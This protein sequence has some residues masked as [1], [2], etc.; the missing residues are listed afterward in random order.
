MYRDAGFRHVAYEPPL[1]QVL[2][3]RVGTR[4]ELMLKKLSKP[5]P[6]EQN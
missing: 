5:E 6:S 3:G 2:E 1:L 4:L